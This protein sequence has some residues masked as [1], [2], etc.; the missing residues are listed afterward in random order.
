[1][2][3]FGFVF[4]FLRE[5][6]WNLKGTAHQL[7]SCVFCMAPAPGHCQLHQLPQSTQCRPQALLVTR[8][9]YRDEHKGRGDWHDLGSLSASGDSPAPRPPHTSSHRSPPCF[10]SGTMDHSD[11]SFSCLIRQCP[12]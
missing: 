7:H 2:A 8:S 9:S 5:M 6:K 10:F 1:M 4:C 12:C 11:F 3:F